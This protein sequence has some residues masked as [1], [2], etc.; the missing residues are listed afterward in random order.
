MVWLRVSL[1]KETKVTAH[2]ANNCIDNSG[3]SEHTM[4]MYTM[5]K[6]NM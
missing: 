3:I 5:H 2:C 6:V 4:T 1:E